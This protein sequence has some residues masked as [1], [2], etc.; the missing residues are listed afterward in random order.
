MFKSK[1]KKSQSNFKLLQTHVSKPNFSK[2]ARVDHLNLETQ[3]TPQ[4]PFNDFINNIT[5]FARQNAYKLI[6]CLYRYHIYKYQYLRIAT[7]ESLTAGLIMSTLVDIPL[8]GGYKYGGYI[9]YDTDA[10]HKLN[11]LSKNDLTYNYLYSHQCSKA[12]AFNLLQN[13]NASIAIAVSGNAM[14][15]TENTKDLG[16]VYLTIAGFDE[17]GSIIFINYKIDVCKSISLFELTLCKEWQKNQGEGKL[18]EVSDTATL[19]IAI[20]YYTAIISYSLCKDFIDEYKPFSRNRL[21]I[22][23]ENPFGQWLPQRKKLRV[24]EILPVTKEKEI[25]KLMIENIEEINTHIKSLLENINIDQLKTLR[26]TVNYWERTTQENQ[27][28]KASRRARAS[29]TPRLTATSRRFSRSVPRRARAPVTPRTATQKS[30]R[31]AVKLGGKKKKSKKIRK[32][33]K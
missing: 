20:R 14:P 16:I 2:I 29:D 24:I 32:S 4:G 22:K 10:K 9:V 7:S 6:V 27:S 28:K 23:K 8:F 26:N 21:Q 31:P 25:S 12:M 5:K 15:R 18:N 13:S 1:V 30:H 3:I 17:N 19:S 11:G 33:K